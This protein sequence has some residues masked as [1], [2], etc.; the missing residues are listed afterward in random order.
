MGHKYTN[1]LVRPFIE[2]RA[3]SQKNDLSRRQR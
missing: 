3:V 2:L 1:K